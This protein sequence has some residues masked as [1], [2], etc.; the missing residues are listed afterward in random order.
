MTLGELNALSGRVIG[1]AIEVHR[2]LGPGL[3]ESSYQ[4][5]LL[6]EL[7]AHGM[8]A[9]GEVPVPL[10]YKGVELDTSFRADIIVENELVVELKSTEK[11]N[12]LYAK[13]LMTYLR[14]LNRRLGLL[15]NFNRE[16]L[17]DGVERVIA[18]W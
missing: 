2:I 9:E 13:Q 3:L 12:P 17:A 10:V 1:C 11:D 5:A 7:R 6:Y 8:H 16:K 4:A 15:I 14:I 18:G